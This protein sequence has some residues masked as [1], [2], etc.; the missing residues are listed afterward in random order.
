M[1]VFRDGFKNYPGFR[2]QEKTKE[3]ISLFAN[4]RLTKHAQMQKLLNSEDTSDDAMKLINSLL[5]KAQGV[6]VWVKL[7]A[8]VILE[9][10]TD[11]DELLEL[12]RRLDDL[13]EELEE[14]Y[15]RILTKIKKGQTQQSRLIF[16]ILLRG[17]GTVGLFQLALALKG[18]EAALS[19]LIKE[20]SVTEREQICDHMERIVN[21]RCGGLLEIVGIASAIQ[22]TGLNLW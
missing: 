21:S 11:G 22:V 4:A 16:D 2:I 15:E 7:V 13:P 18:R 6:F 3:E 17:E 5:E 8:N 10:L 1:E 20:M 14:L 9:G 12:Q 19:C